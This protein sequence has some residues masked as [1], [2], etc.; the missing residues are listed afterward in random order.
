MFKPCCCAAHPSAVTFLLD[1][2]A[3]LPVA[4]GRAW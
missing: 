3:E 4:H 2:L 1:T